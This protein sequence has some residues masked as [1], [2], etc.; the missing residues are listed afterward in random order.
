MKKNHVSP[1]NLYPLQLVISILVF[2]FKR[3]FS[4]IIRKRKYPT[5]RSKLWSNAFRSLSFFA[6]SC[7]GTPISG[8]RQYIGRQ[9][10]P[11]QKLSF[12]S[13]YFSP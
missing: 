13:R 1:V 5:V 4:M 7:G 8:I 3:T 12:S 6:S 2:K 9:R 10:T 11:D